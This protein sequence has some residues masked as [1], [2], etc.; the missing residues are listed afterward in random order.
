[1]IFRWKVEI[2]GEKIVIYFEKILGGEGNMLE[3]YYYMNR[4][5][6]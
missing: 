3:K 2:Y 4:E 6:L 5:Y 1:M